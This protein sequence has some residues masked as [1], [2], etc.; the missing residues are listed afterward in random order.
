MAL[1]CK[2]VAARWLL[3]TIRKQ[4]DT[5]LNLNTSS[6]TSHLQ[7]APDNLIIIYTYT[8]HVLIR[9]LA[10]SKIDYKLKENTQWFEI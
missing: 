6:H 7:I 5:T 4:Y 3:V 10:K 1:D 8:L 9:C 2:M